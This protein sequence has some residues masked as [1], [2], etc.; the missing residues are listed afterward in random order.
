MPYLPGKPLHGKHRERLP[1][2]WPAD[3]PYLQVM[4]GIMHIQSNTAAATK[5]YPFLTADDTYP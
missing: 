5:G 3:R 4:D 1:I 2:T